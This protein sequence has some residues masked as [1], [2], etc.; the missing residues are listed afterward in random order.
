[1]IEINWH[2]SPRE[3]RIF[4]AL[5][6]LFFTLIAGIVYSQ[7]DSILAANAIV[8][9]ATAI[10]VLGLRMPKFL[11]VLYLGWMLATFPIGWLLAH[12]AIA[13]VYYLVLTPIGLTLRLLGR[14][15]M[16]KNF[17]P[18][19]PSYWQPRQETDDPKQYFRQF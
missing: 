15:S 1:M 8:A 18:S 2:P 10:V 7:T 16:N 9:T 11:R 17:D 4:A 19:T 6:I 14:D 5:W 12:V 3:L 13:I